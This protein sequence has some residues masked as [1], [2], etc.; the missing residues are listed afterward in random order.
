MADTTQFQA[1]ARSTADKFTGYLHA[2][3]KEMRSFAACVRAHHVVIEDAIRNGVPL[4]A[5]A[6][7]LSQAYGVRGSLAALKSALNRIR[8]M[9]EA[10]L[11]RQWYDQVD[12]EQ[13][14]ASAFRVEPHGNAHPMNG[15]MPQQ[16]AQAVR[17]YGIPTMAQHLPG[18]STSMPGSGYP[19][20]PY[21]A[22]QQ[23]S[24]YPYGQSDDRY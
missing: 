13:Y 14:G 4:E 1:D 9:R 24:I 6:H 2:I 18:A 19:Y 10:E 22:P 3:S 23:R 20:P 21:V 16:S 7:G 15:R 11:D 8:R 12:R 5:I 17:P